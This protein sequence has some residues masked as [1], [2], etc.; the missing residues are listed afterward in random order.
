MR[1]RMRNADPGYQNDADSCASGSGSTTLIIINKQVKKVKKNFNLFK[2]FEFAFPLSHT[3]T[4]SIPSMSKIC[5]W[6]E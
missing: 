6:Y 1:I 4:R 5:V 2:G 3:G